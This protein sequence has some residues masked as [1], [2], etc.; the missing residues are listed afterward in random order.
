MIGQARI[1]SLSPKP[2]GS[3]WSL[4]VGGLSLG[5]RKKGEARER[6]KGRGIRHMITPLCTT[7]DVWYSGAL[8]Q[9]AHARQGYLELR[10]V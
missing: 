7:S 1:S 3:R 8:V 2:S 4:W 5:S 6:G 10:A 9:P